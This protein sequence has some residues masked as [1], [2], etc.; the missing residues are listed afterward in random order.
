MNAPAPDHLRQEPLDA[1]PLDR[2]MPLIPG[3][4]IAGRALIASTQRFTLAK[5]ARMSGSRFCCENV[6]G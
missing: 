2:R 5:V 6:Q 3:D 1:P 4:S